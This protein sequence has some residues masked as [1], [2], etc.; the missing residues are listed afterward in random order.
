MVSE[1]L[2]K[3]IILTLVYTENN[4]SGSKKYIFLFLNIFLFIILD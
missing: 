1:M 2:N 4:A 3:M